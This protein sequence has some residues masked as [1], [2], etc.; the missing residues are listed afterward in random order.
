MAIRA[1][2]ASN[3]LHPEADSLYP[4]VGASKLDD[5]IPAALRVRMAAAGSSAEPPSPS[6]SARSLT[7]VPGPAHGDAWFDEDRAPSVSLS[8]VEN[9]VETSHMIQDLH[10]RT[11]PPSLSPSSSAMDLDARA[12]TPPPTAPLAFVSLG[13]YPWLLRHPMPLSGFLLAGWFESAMRNG[14]PASALE[15]LVRTETAPMTA[16][17]KRAVPKK[18]KTLQKVVE[19]FTPE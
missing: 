7:P 4:P 19:A 14:V 3:P 9:L 15:C 6:P 10:S 11:P 12:R 8:Q 18:L 1:V 17:E 16:A 5:L 13:D 2:V